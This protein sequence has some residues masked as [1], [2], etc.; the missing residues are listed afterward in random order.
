MTTLLP[1]PSTAAGDRTVADLLKRLGGVPPERV[2]LV[3]T[4][5]TATEKD[6]VAMDDHADRLCEL[7]DGVLVEK[8]MGN[9]ESA[10]ALA[11]G[12]FLR[13]FI[14]RRRLGVLTGTD[15]PYRILPE[16]VRMPDVA[17]VSWE[18]LGAS[19][20]PQEAILGVAPDLA[21]EVLSKSNTK[22]EME[23]KLRDYFSAGVRL[24][25]YIEPKKRTAKSY[26]APDACQAIGEDG[27]LDGGEVRPGFELSLRELFAEAEG[28]AT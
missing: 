14:R 27:S 19:R 10:V 21:V 9:Y 7:I 2:L 12:Y 3:P 16:Q 4:P 15:G 28:A 1:S 6:V 24:V 25:W 8:T 26:T 23:R 5:G 17:F 22:G 11:V 20:L 18:R 13:D